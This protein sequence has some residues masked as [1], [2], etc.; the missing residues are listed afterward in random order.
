MTERPAAEFH[1]DEIDVHLTTDR[2][3]ASLLLVNPTQAVK[4]SMS[5]AALER[6]RD[7]ISRVLSGPIPPIGR[8]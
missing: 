4:V 3:W 6:L 5:V 7:R 1:A 8:A 2:Q